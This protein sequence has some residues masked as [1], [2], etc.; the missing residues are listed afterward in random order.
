MIKKFETMKLTAVVREHK[1]KKN[2]EI[3]NISI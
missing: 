3:K 2:T 1:K